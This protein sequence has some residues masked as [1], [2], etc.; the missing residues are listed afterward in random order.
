MATP[1]RNTADLRLQYLFEKVTD[2]SQTGP[3]V[4]TTSAIAS[5]TGIVCNSDHANLHIFAA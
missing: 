5:T 1:G 2:S 4:V 3:G